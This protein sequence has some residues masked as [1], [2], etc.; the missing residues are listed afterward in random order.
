MTYK[1]TKAAKQFTAFVISSGSD[2]TFQLRKEQ[3][4]SQ[5]PSLTAMVN[6][7]LAGTSKCVLDA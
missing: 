7:L 6:P 3:I 4:Y 1:K 2:Q 5:M